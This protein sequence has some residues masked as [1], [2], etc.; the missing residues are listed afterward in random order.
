MSHYCKV[1]AGHDMTSCKFEVVF[2]RV[3]HYCKVVAGHDMTSRKFE[4]VFSACL[5]IIKSTMLLG[6]SFSEL[7]ILQK[8][9]CSYVVVNN[10]DF[11]IFVFERT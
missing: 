8:L 2:F 4:L 10:R 11:P 1:V 5:I 3:S 9:I 6:F 7:Y